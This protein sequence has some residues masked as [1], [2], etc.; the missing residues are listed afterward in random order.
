MAAVGVNNGDSVASSLRERLVD[1]HVT[2]GRM[3]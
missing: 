3:L 1:L 2:E